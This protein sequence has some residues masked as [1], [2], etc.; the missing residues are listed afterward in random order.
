MDQDAAWKR[1]FGQPVVVRHLLRGFAGKVVDLLDLDTLQQLPASW[2]AADGEQRRGDMAWRASYADGSGRSL[3]L[4]IEFQS[5]VDHGMSIR[6]I[7]YE[8]MAFGGLR[9]AKQLDQ[10]H[11]LRLLSVVIYSGEGRWTAPGGA[12]HVVLDSTGEVGPPRPG[13]YLLLDTHSRAQDDAARSNIVAAALW[14]SGASSPA[15]AATRLRELVHGWSASRNV[16]AA[17]AV[18]EWL[19]ILWPRLFPDADPTT[20]AAWRRDLL[21]EEEGMS[22]LAERVREWEADLLHQGIEQGIEQGMER[23]IEDQR[24]MLRG[25]AERKFGPVT[26]REL[27]RRLANVTDAERLAVVG[28]WIIDCDTGAAL[29]EQVDTEVGNGP[30]DPA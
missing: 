23:G 24:A 13:R 4:L 25:Q 16:E 6:V 8:A 22:T 20:L 15:D 11:E 12:A 19:G 18:L 9:H 27:A 21:N 5:T 30:A 1:L 14:L 29:L 10:D 17:D 7:R 26:A 3:V 28:G 2:V